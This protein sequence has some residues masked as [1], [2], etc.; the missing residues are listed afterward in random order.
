MNTIDADKL[1][2]KLDGL[3][4]S[5]EDPRTRSVVANWK[6]PMTKIQPSGEA[7][8]VFDAG[9]GRG[10]AYSIEEAWAETPWGIVRNIYDDIQDESW[11]KTPEETCQLIIYGGT[12][13]NKLA[14]RLRKNI[15]KQRRKKQSKSG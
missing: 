8:L 11:G 2:A 10:I 3:F 1:N 15:E 13:D 7:W 9:N 5:F 14:A 6:R 12:V 4:A